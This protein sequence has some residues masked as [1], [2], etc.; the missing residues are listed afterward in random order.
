MTPNNNPD[1]DPSRRNFLRL[2]WSV[3]AGV[4]VPP[5]L[6][7]ACGGGDGGPVVMETFVEPQVLA[8]VNGKLDVTLNLAYLKTELYGKKVN[9]RNMY[10]TIPAPTMRVNAGDTIRV[11]LVN[12]FPANP[13][14]LPSSNP[15]THLRYP[16]STNLHMHG[17]HVTPGLVSTVPKVYG[18]YVVDD[19]EQGVHPGAS[20]QHQYAIGADHPPGAYWYHPH[21]HGSS[22]MQVGSGM[23]GAILIKGAI[24]QVPEIAAARERVFM[25]QAPILDEAGLLESFVQIAENGGGVASTNQVPTGEPPFIINGV[26]LPRLVMRSGEVQNWHFVNAAIFKYLNLSLDSHAL[27]V[28]SLDGN[29]RSPLKPVGPIVPDNKTSNQEGV[30]LAPGNRASILVKAGAPGTYL[31]RTLNFSLSG[32]G[33]NL[34]AD[35]LAEV[36]VLNESSPMNLPAGPLPIPKALAPITDQELASAGGLKRTVVFRA[37]TNPN[38]NGPP[39]PANKFPITDQPASDVV[40]PMGELNDWIYNALNSLGKP[41]TLSDTVLGVGTMS[42]SGPPSKLIE[43]IPFQSARAKKQTVALGSVEEWTVYNMNGIRHPFH[44]HVNPCWVVK[45]SDK[46]DLEPYWADT[47]PLPPGS[48]DK[49]GWVTFRS[50]FLD[51]KGAYVLHCHML[52]HEDMGM[53]QVVEVV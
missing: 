9:L 4:A 48:A 18:D 11:L 41:N 12:Q 40:H 27:N 49:P 14:V 24:D 26:R 35:V 31:L 8:S 44:I 53:M 33:A 43:I 25:F 28:Y 46:P 30:V 37:V 52:A 22:A 21:L 7:Q 29:T 6:L 23:A 15:P 34:L 36:V 5:M 38:F 51:F 39:G 17:L 3:A 20:R 19:P 32:G 45:V 1:R 2:G 10:G 47:V 50:R 42:T 13:P 16:N